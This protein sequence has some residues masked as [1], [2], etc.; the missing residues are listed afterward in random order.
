MRNFLEMM[1]IFGL[2]KDYSEKMHSY[3]GHTAEQI[4]AFMEKCFGD[5]RIEESGW[6]YDVTR[7]KYAQ[8]VAYKPLTAIS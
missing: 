3:S 2:A 6:V 7:R 1:T 4:K 8:I 5:V